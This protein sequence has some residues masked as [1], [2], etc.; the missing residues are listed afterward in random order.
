MSVLKGVPRERALRNTEGRPGVRILSCLVLGAM[1]TCVM[2]W[3]IYALPSSGW[4]YQRWERVPQAFPRIKHVDGGPFRVTKQRVQW[5]WPAVGQ[6]PVLGALIAPLE[7]SLSGAG[8]VN[9]SYRGRWVRYERGSMEVRSQGNAPG[10]VIISGRGTYPGDALADR[11]RERYIRE[12]DH[13]RL[14]AYDQDVARWYALARD[15]ETLPSWSSFRHEQFDK[16]HDRSPTTPGEVAALYEPLNVIE[17]AAGW[18]YL[19][20]YQRRVMTRP[21]HAVVRSTLHLPIP[22]IT[23]QTVDQSSGSGLGMALPLTPLWPGFVLNTMLYGG[24]LWAGWTVNTA[25]LARLVTT[26]RRRRDRCVRWRCGYPLGGH[27]ICPECG[28]EQRP[29][30]VP[31]PKM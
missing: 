25:A 28:T 30:P 26:H 18:P 14:K 2:S 7:D 11:W 22:W 8:A 9:G 5:P 15:P 12:G 20:M 10:L 1:L 6:E 31:R 21:Q 16:G 27:P 24:L 3:I 13:D 29:P 23:D 4:R 19:A 17:H